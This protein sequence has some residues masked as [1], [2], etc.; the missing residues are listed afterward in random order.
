MDAYHLG[1]FETLVQ[2][3]VLPSV[4]V[5]KG[6]MIGGFGDIWSGDWP[7]GDR[8]SKVEKLEMVSEKYRGPHLEKLCLIF[9][10]WDYDHIDTDQPIASLKCF[11]KL[12][13]LEIDSYLLIHRPDPDPDKDEFS[14]N[15]ERTRRGHDTP[16]EQKDTPRCHFCGATLSGRQHEKTFKEGRSNH[17]NDTSESEVIIQDMICNHCEAKYPSSFLPLPQKAFIP[18]LIDILPA[19][20]QKLRMSFIGHITCQCQ[21]LF[22]DIVIDGRRNEEIPHL[23]RIE[24]AC[25]LT[26]LP[27][28][29]LPDLRAAG[30][31]VGF[32]VPDSGPDEREGISGTGIAEHALNW[33]NAR[34]GNGWTRKST[35]TV[36]D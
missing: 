19:L 35:M 7:H 24:L 8:H 28:R 29:M 5:L 21:R 36:I 2:W 13:L 11:T 1:D 25:K 30:I 27:Q 9:E 16:Y 26:D 12:K 17:N 33:N 3:S 10:P 32:I 34:W 23:T 4:R 18:K 6:F 20:I 31:S 14:W 15:A 22:E